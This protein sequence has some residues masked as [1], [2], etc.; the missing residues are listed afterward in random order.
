[1]L[2]LVDDGQSVD[3]D[4]GDQVHWCSVHSAVRLKQESGWD[5]RVSLGVAG[6]LLAACAIGVI[7]LA[8]GAGGV[9]GCFLMGCL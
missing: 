7:V 2:V 6:R 4:F 8:D 9:N 5:T 3:V 1:M